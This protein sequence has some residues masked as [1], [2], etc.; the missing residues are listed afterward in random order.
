MCTRNNLRTTSKLTMKTRLVNYREGEINLVF[1]L[2]RPRVT[3]GRDVDNMIQLPNEKV[4]KHH[5]VI[6][7]SK[8]GWVIEDLKSRN[9]V[10]VNGSRT[11]RA[12]LKER[13]QVRIGPYEFYFETNVPSE[14]FVPGY[15]IDISTKSRDQT[16][17]EKKPPEE[18]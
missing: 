1:S 4:S 8:G 13:D 2:D 17:L 16:I 15:I 10:F 12:D 5:G 14:D 3:I 9:G 7:Q 6:Y 11:E 18:N